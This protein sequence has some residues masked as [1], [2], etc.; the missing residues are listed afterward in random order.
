MN[1]AERMQKWDE[2]S[3]PAEQIETT[4]ET[5]ILLSTETRGGLNNCQWCAYL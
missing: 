5:T 3:A 1:H 4:A 2:S